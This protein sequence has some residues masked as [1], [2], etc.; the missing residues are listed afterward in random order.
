MAE[1]IAES[2][3]YSKIICTDVLEAPSDNIITKLGWEHIDTFLNVRTN[4][5]VNIS[6][7]KII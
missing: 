5:E 4:N 3:G 7:K 2:L 6:I 1:N